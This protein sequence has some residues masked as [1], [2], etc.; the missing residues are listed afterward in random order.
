VCLVGNI[1]DSSNIDSILL[2][3]QKREISFHDDYI[4]IHS[5]VHHQL[6]APIFGNI[7]PYAFAAQLTDERKMFMNVNEVCSPI[8]VSKNSCNCKNATFY[9]DAH[10]VVLL[11]AL[12]VFTINIS[13]N[14]YCCMYF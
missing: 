6:S 7:L 11:I 12:L 3:E 5:L 10:D 2:I 8:N 13:Y 9:S 4:K 1:D 14:M